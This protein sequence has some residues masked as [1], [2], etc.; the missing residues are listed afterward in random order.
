[1]YSFCE[2]CKVSGGERRKSLPFGHSREEATVLFV[3]P[4]FFD[5][6]EQVIQDLLTGMYPGARFVTYSACGNVEDFALALLAC[7]VLLRNE[8][9]GFKRL[10]LPKQLF[11]EVQTKIEDGIVTG[12]YDGNSPLKPGTVDEYRRVLNADA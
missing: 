9:I 7:K 12:F 4:H 5:S 1:M 10:M 6:R 8:V 2:Y 3:L 11:E